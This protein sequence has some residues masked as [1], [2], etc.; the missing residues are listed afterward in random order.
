MSDNTFEKTLFK[1]SCKL[2]EERQMSRYTSFKIGGKADYVVKPGSIEELSSI[3]QAAKLHGI[4]YFFLGSGSN[5]LVSDDGYRGLVILTA[6]LNHVELIDDTHII[7]ECGV[8]ISRLCCVAHSNGLSG[9]EFAYG[10]P[11]SVGGGIYM[12][13]G[14]YG[15]ECKDVIV[16]CSFLDSDGAINTVPIEKLEM[17]YRS[18]C[19]TGKKLFIL[20]G[21]FELVKASKVDI[22]NKMNDYMERRRSKQPLEY[23]SGGSTFKRPAN[24]FASALI[25]ECGLKGY[26][27]GG[28]QVSEKHAGFI[29]NKGGATCADVLALIKHI[30]QVVLDK[31]NVQLECE[32]EMLGNV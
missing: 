24:H 25:E 27:V 22:K 11:G 2:E 15:G 5:L 4:D 8:P 10:I 29:I 19:F 14:A 6:G 13:A 7:C 31:K 12:N 9:L 3:V 23:P 21:I 32:V 18:S 26:S 28:A 17:S 1:L 16:S 20:S 30:Q